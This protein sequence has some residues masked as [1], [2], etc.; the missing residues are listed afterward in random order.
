MNTLDLRI[1]GAK[2]YPT[3]KAV[4]S[5]ADVVS[6]QTLELPKDRNFT[7]VCVVPT[8]RDRATDYI[9]AQLEQ[10]GIINQPPKTFGAIALQLSMPGT[11]EMPLELTA[12]PT[13]AFK[14]LSII[15]FA[16]MGTLGARNASA[17]YRG[18]SA[19]VHAEGR[20]LNGRPDFGMVTIQAFSAQG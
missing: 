10:A 13:G 18:V 2:G 14:R 16:G 1:A 4:D 3:P 19:E 7:V 8:E 15:E 5:D 12:Q 20:F 6:P 11:E 9:R 17:P